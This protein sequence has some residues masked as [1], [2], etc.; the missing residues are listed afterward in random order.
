MANHPFAPPAFGPVRGRGALNPAFQP[1][2]LPRGRGRQDAW[3]APRGRG[4]GRE[5]GLGGLPTRRDLATI[6][7]PAPSLPRQIRIN[8]IVFDLDAKGSKLTRIT[9]QCSIECT[10]RND[11]MLTVNSSTGRCRNT[12][13]APDRKRQVLSNEERQSLPLRSVYGD[14]T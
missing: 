10:A 9:R 7:S 4:Q 2:P 6:S 3:P 8:D 11:C 5:P 12:L 14:A 1:Y 13:R